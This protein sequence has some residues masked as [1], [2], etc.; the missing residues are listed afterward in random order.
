MQRY[1]IT[2]AR[3]EGAEQTWVLL[4][5]IESAT[6]QAEEH[7]NREKTTHVRVYRE[8]PGDPARELVLDLPPKGASPPSPLH[9]KHTDGEG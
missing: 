1:R 5:D 8:A 3:G 4:P 7:R 2:I 9:P 6:M